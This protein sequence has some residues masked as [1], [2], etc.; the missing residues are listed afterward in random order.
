MYETRRRFLGRISLAA[1]GVLLAR[2][3][4]AGPGRELSLLNTHTGE[5]VRATY[6]ETGRYQPDALR[7]IDRLL[8][9]HRTGEV[10]EIERGLLDLLHE[11]R[12]TLPVRDHYHVISGYRSPATNAL[13]H[14]RSEGVARRSLHVLGRAVDVRLPGV[15]LPELRRAALALRRG[16]VGYYPA[17]DFVHL[18]TGRVRSW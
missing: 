6:W 9:D 15:T 18:D 11:L 1:A 8:R 14:A 16:G 7:E 13:L 5:R 2:G 3:A 12:G 4:G 17:S 10:K